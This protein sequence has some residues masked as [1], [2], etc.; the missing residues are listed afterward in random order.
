MKEEQEEEQEAV[1]QLVVEV[2]LCV[3]DSLWPILLLSLVVAEARCFS[4][5][6]R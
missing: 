2:K 5:S 6:C 4:L 3:F 1:F